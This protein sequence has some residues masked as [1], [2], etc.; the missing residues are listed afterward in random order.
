MAV[1]VFLL[2]GL[3]LLLLGMELLTQGLRQAAGERLRVW[4]QRSTRTRWRGA[5]SGFLITALVQSSSAVTVATLGLT[6]AAMVNLRQAAWVVFGSNLGTTMTA[7]IVALIGLSW[8]VE[9]LA[10]PLIGLGVLLHV[11]RSGK[12]AGFIGTALAGFGLLFF[13]LEMLKDAF[14]GAGQW[15]PVEYLTLQSPL[16]LLAGVLLGMV[17]TT[18]LQSSSAAL[19]VVLTAA[20]QGFIGPLMGAALVIGANLGTTSTA[21]LATLGATSEAKR[22]ALVHVMFNVLTAVVALVLLWPLWWVTTWLTDAASSAVLATQLALFHT[23]FNVLGL[24]LMW[25]L[26]DPLLRWVAGRY[27]TQQE[28]AAALRF[29]DDTVLGVAELGLAALNQELKQVL[30]EQMQQLAAQ[31]DSDR[32]AAA[33]A[34]LEQR[35]LKVASAAGHLPNVCA[36]GEQQ[37]G[38]LHGL[39]ALEELRELSELQAHLHVSS[40][41]PL[42]A[43][44]QS[45]LHSLL[46]ALHRGAI[47]ADE[48]AALRLGVSEAR[49]AV[50]ER[51]LHQLQGT[52]QQVSAEA[53][54]RSLALCARWERVADQ[55]ARCA[56]LLWLKAADTDQPPAAV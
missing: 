37:R 33:R 46:A 31:A 1:A 40:R 28:D 13:G 26:A 49:Q 2:G 32:Q 45:A 10:L 22:L 51:L 12:T 34:A 3:G 24:L 11:L 18:L 44:L 43:E 27:R 48:L 55:L 25:P 8:K 5:L 52:D 47:A 17:L 14:D 9:T 42:P 50:R 56:R 16:H 54:A 36:T 19:A 41:E 35:L 29:L 21:L 39:H 4:L 53:V 15:L 20:S 6:N 7:W 23:L 38:L 30:A